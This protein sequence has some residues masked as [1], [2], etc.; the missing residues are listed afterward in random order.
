MSENRCSCSVPP[1]TLH[2]RPSPVLRQDLRLPCFCSLLCSL[3]ASRLWPEQALLRMQCLGTT[4]RVT[5]QCEGPALVMA[6]ASCCCGNLDC[7]TCTAVAACRTESNPLATTLLLAAAPHGGSV[8][9]D[10]DHQQG[11]TCKGGSAKSSGFRP[12]LY[13]DR[14]QSPQ[15]PWAARPASSIKAAVH[16]KHLLMERVAITLDHHV[17]KG[18]PRIAI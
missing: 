3:F 8:L 6:Y 1:R 2:K 12:L 17:G 9:I 7:C 10:R 14:L 13:G 15:L 16:R 4:R 18:P 11:D 5:P